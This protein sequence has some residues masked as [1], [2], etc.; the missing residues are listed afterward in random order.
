MPAGFSYPG[1]MAAIDDRRFATRTPTRLEI[2]VATADVACKRGTNLAGVWFAVEAA[3]QRA[4]I[5]QHRAEFAAIKN[6][7]A[8]RARAAQTLL[9]TQNPPPEKRKPPT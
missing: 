7:I 9:A 6:L 1:P 5:G 2:D 4:A 8:T 3:R